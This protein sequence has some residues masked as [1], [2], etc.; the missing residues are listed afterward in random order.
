MET[1]ASNAGRRG[2]AALIVK[3]ASEK[4]R[5]PAG[6]GA[7]DL[8]G[9]ADPGAE[10]AAAAADANGIVGDPYVELA[11][12]AIEAMQAGD[13]SALAAIFRAVRGM[14]EDDTTPTG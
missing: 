7:G 11:T 12:E 9:S 13:A 4:A 2:L 10:G 1:G 3:D 5:A 8:I 6:V 14:P